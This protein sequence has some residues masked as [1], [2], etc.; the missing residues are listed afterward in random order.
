MLRFAAL[1]WALLS[2]AELC[3]AILKDSKKS[4]SCWVMLRNTEQRWTDFS[5]QLLR[6]KKKD[7]SRNG[8]YDLKS[9]PWI[10]ITVVDYRSM[11]KHSTRTKKRDGKLSCQ[12]HD[13]YAKAHTNPSG[14]CT[15]HF[16]KHQSCVASSRSQLCSA[17]FISSCSYGHS[18]WSPVILQ[19]HSQ[20][21]RILKTLSESCTCR[22]IQIL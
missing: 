13:P 19:N 15:L 7:D 16:F 12:F 11:S 17:I 2:Y 1:C 3:W 8:S 14:S 21:N 5:G 20:W 22:T 9:I 18:S 4:W 6:Q 10:T